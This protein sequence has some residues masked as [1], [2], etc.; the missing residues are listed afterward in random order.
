MLTPQR[1]ANPL[2][3]RASTSASGVPQTPISSQLE[4]N[5]WLK[6][7]VTL[8]QPEPSP[9]LREF[10][11]AC[12]DNPAEPIKQQL[13][14]Q[15]QRVEEHL[16]KVMEISCDVEELILLSRK[17]YYKMLLAFLQAEQQRLNVNDFSKL[18]SNR[19]FHCS[20]LACCMEA[21]FAANSVDEAA[22]PAVL[23]LLDLHAFDFAKVIE[24]FVKT[25]PRL[26][27]HLRA[28]F[29]D[30][31][32]KILEVLAW[33]DGSPLHGLMS[34]Y[35]AASEASGSPGPNRAKVALEQFIKKVWY[36]AAVRIQEICT[37]LLLPSFLVHQVWNC[38]KLVLKQCRHLLSGRHLDQIVMC[39][40]YGVCKVNQRSVTF[41]HIIEQYKRQPK[42]SPKVFREVRMANKSD[43]PQDIICFYNQVYIPAMK[44]CL[45]EVVSK[46]TTG[47]GAAGSGDGP[48][49]VMASPSL[50]RLTRGS[51]SPQR[52]SA[53][54]DVYVSQPR[55]PSSMTPRTKTLYA[56]GDTPAAKLQTI[57]LQLNRTPGSDAGAMHVLHQMRSSGN[58]PAP[59]PAAA[60]QSPSEE[61]VSEP[62]GR[63]RSLNLS[64]DPTSN[65]GGRSMRRR[66]E[67]LGG[68]APERSDSQASGEAS[69][70]GDNSS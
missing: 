22:F 52:V 34:E 18:L 53:Q 24:S 35:D 14:E 17:L 26:P 58:S 37:R 63:K 59:Q 40:V 6:D 28:H 43:K 36:L 16:C 69:D 61:E 27:H 68:A 41:R 4:S 25:E 32:A 7:T 23:G 19:A 2:C 11:G 1:Q 45:M 9:E 47:E 56:F 21:V 33:A 10:F 44:E 51:A 60:G 12:Q 50:S 20:L 42:A 66:L 62:G 31:E 38:L 30:V 46:P 57:N 15:C 39:T 29:A 49:G 67:S 54:R 55:T 5:K 70:M 8:L 65:G 48:G 64:Q 13:Q 3:S